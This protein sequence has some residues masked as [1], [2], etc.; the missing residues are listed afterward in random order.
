MG[1]VELNEECDNQT[2]AFT[3]FNK[4]LYKRFCNFENFQIECDNKL[5]KYNKDNI[6]GRQHTNSSD[7]TYSL[8]VEQI[9][10]TSLVLN[11]I[12]E[13]CLGVAMFDKVA[14]VGNYVELVRPGL[15]FCELVWVGLDSKTSHRLDLSMWMF[16]SQR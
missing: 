15:P 14:K 9:D 13:P 1:C 7:S 6:L 8:L 4:L 2:F 3:E 10:T 5:R 12:Q 11:D 16:L